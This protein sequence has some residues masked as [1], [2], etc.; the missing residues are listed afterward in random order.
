[1]ADTQ[2][3]VYTDQHYFTRPEK[4]KKLNTDSILFCCARKFSAIFTSL[5][6]STV[7]FFHR[8][9]PT[10]PVVFSTAN[11][12]QIRGYYNASKP[13]V[14]VFHGHGQSQ[15][16]PEMRNITGVYL[17]KVSADRFSFWYTFHV[18]LLQ[19]FTLYIVTAD[20]VYVLQ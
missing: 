20:S 10:Y 3:T 17:T 2:I 12:S 8:S 18:P 16:T 6:Y 11:F 5:K 15:D 13:T 1:M 7:H 9:N 4:N 14:I 19:I